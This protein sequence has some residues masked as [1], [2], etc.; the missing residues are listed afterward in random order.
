MHSTKTL[1]VPGIIGGAGPGAT[2]RLYLDIVSRCR[3][4]GLVHRPPIL[5]ASLDIDLAMEDRLLRE[6]VGI[7]GY[8]DSLLSAARSLVAAGA[9]FL[10]VP[11]NSLHV[12][13]PE[14][15]T[16]LPVSVVSI[17]EAVVREVEICGFRKVGLLATR[18]TI[19]AGI[20]QEGLQQ[21]GV[22]VVSITPDL[23]GVLEERIQAEVDQRLSADAAELEHAIADFFTA[24]A[25]RAVVAGCTELKSLMASW[26][27]PLPVIDS[28]DALGVMVVR[29]MLLDGV[30]R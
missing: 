21:R 9:D 25:V 19:S 29:E 22:E 27:L 16:A 8:R 5:I 26:D 14:L 2:A 12:L 15:T 13:L 30:V 4:S 23:Q 20:Y 10:A 18:T 11:C 3:R 6:G 17:V 24:Q 1:R 28:L 7:E